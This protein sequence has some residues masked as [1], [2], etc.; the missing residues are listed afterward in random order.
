MIN[1]GPSV[2]LNGELPEE[3][4]TGKEA[5]L[6][7][8]RVFGCVS[9]VHVDSN[10]RDKLDLKSRKYFFIKYG[11]DDFGYHFWDEENRKIIRQRNVI[12]NK[13]LLYKYMSDVESE[14]ASEETQ[15]TAQV[16]L[17]EI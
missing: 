8:L 9:Y 4:W 2:P 16:E 15:K 3:A 5:T 11:S 12:F 6:L 13:K 17:E 7:H 10:D 1:R 14:D